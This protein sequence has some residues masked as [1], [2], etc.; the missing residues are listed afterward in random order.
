MATRLGARYNMRVQRGASWED[1]FAYTDADG[2]AINL[3]GYKARMQ[4][5]TLVGRYGTTTAS[6]LLLELNSTNGKLVI[7]TPATAGTLT[8]A[9]TP[10]D[11]QTLSPLNKARVRLAYSIE[12]YNDGV[13]P[14]H[15]IPLAH[16]V[17][18][19]LG[20]NTR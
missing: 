9:A 3:T 13:S 11:T 15:V 1:T 20:E 7:D 17:V 18:T 10:A 8:L 4:V 14:E 19:V 6:T 5:R 12:L 2:V 16:G